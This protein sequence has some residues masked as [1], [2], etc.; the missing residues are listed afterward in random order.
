MSKN[1]AETGSKK[2][3]TFV[4]AFK[5]SFVSLFALILFVIAVAG[6]VVVGALAGV[7]GNTDL[8]AVENIRETLSLNLTSFIYAVDE[9]GNAH[10]LEVLYDEE[11]R[12]WA[13]LEEIPEHLQHAFISIED[14]RFEKHSGFD[15]K[16]TFGAAI[17]YLQKKV[18]GSGESAYGG[19]TIT[20][21]LIKNITGDDDYSIDRKIQEIYRAYV[22]EQDLTKD[23]ILELYLNTIYLSQQC[24]GVKSAAKVY[25]NKNLN[26]LS[27]AECATIAA[28]TQFPTKYD[29]KRN[30]ENNKERR[31]VI[32]NKMCELGYI[33][34]A[35]RDAAKSESVVTVNASETDAYIS[36]TTYYSDALIEQLISDLV[37]E[38][39]V[40]KAVAEKM[41]YSGGLKIY[42]AM[43]MEIQAI[44]DEYYLDDS[45]FPKTSGEVQVQSAMVIID[46]TTGYVSGVVG[47]RG[48]KDSS[49]TLNRATQTLRQPGSSIKPIAIYSPSVEYGNV[50]SNTIVTDAPLT[51]GS[52]TPRNDDRDFRGDITVAAALAG[53]R[54]VPAVR[55]L[56]NLGITRSFNFLTKNYHI[57]SLV[58][59]RETESGKTFTDKG[60]AAIGL[61]GLTDGVSVL[62]MAAA[63]VPFASKGYYYR[64]SFYTKVLDS[65]GNIILDRTPDPQ[66]AISETTAVTMT[67][68]LR[69][70]VTGGTGTSAR[71]SRMPSAG[72]TGTTS[73]NH[74]RWFVGYTPYYVGA[75]WYG[76]DIPASLRGISGNPSARVWKGVMEKV[77]ADL[78][79]R[80]FNKL[81]T[82]RH[83]LVCA[84][85]GLLI[86]SSCESFAFGDY[87]KEQAP[88]T[89]CDIHL[90]TEYGGSPLQ[91]EYIDPEEASTDVAGDIITEM[92]GGDTGITD[93]T[94][95]P[96]VPPTVDT[97]IVSTPPVADTPS[98]STPVVDPYALPPGV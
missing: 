97:P 8:S 25:F 56:Q 34:E 58:D 19:S 27:L 64:P 79:Y 66:P 87:T 7:I 24:N 28:I 98:V 46:P 90:E 74:D 76:Y 6:G 17:S 48:T 65:E 63:Y 60:F 12:V 37:L 33:T 73:N 41:L 47:G 35:E 36:T 53:S 44:M 91:V 77:H 69:G 93:N 32:L 3:N 23:E 51:I 78:E 62:E 83:Y 54:N 5:I 30:P 38:K 31:N 9:E 42:A 96:T 80:D 92:P 18:T 94:Y 85:S 52:W 88:R 57:S 86:N 40:T 16:R 2:P 39:G 26:E 50:V 55:I 1:K 61:G 22:L 68:M 59:Q 81:D 15:I 13:D 4:K 71:L 21:Q 67:Q 89:R 43:D 20:Q 95:I 14:E 29:P 84:D 70:V 11:N 10:Q 72:K 49:R 82:T 75:V 45:N